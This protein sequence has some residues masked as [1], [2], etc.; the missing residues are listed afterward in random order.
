MQYRYVLLT[1]ICLFLVS[2][3]KE[4]MA[5]DDADPNTTPEKSN[6]VTLIEDTFENTELAIVGSDGRNF[7]VAYNRDLDGEMLSLRVVPNTL[8]VMMEDQKGNRWDLSGKA[9]SG[10]NRGDQLQNVNYG[11]GFWFAFAALY[12]ELQLHQLGSIGGDPHPPTSHDWDIPREY[13][14]QGAGFDAIPSIQSPEFY[15]LG[16]LPAEP[17]NDF[18]LQDDDFVLVVS[19]NGESKAYPHPI[20]DWHEIINDV[21]GGMPVCVTYCPLTGTGKVW[22]RQP[23]NSF[24]VSGLLFNSNLLSFD[25]ETESLWLQLEARCVNGDKLGEVRPIVPSVETKFETARLLYP[26]LKVMTSN[27]GVDRDYSKY[28]Y[29]DYRTNDL[30]S[31]P[32]AFRDDRLPLKERVFGVIINGKAKVY[33]FQHF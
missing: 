22:Q 15:E 31:Y 8:P 29:G 12:P 7:A 30:V 16:N 26:G 6:R 10:P 17:E 24:G 23:S 1:L 32:L 25:R 19:L 4:P 18:Y 20:L 28:P 5:N 13:V 21:V 11:M 14:A 9:I 2:C 3:S 33:T 27:T